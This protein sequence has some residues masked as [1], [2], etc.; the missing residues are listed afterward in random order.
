MELVLH[1]CKRANRR[2]CASPRGLISGG[3]VK[4][5]SKVFR[6]RSIRRKYWPQVA[7]W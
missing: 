5:Y 3:A 7:G 4:D 6:K 2:R 1:I